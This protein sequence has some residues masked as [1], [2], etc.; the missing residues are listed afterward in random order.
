MQKSL[1]IGIV[2]AAISVTFAVLYLWFF[3]GQGLSEETAYRLSIDKANQYAAE[4]HFDLASFSKPS[5]GHQAGNRLYI[6]TWV[7]HDVA[8]NKE[9]SVSVD[10]LLVN[11]EV[12]S[13]D[14]LTHHSSGTP[15]GAP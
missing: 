6:F 14:G 3:Y 15:N 2:A 8:S 10:A 7:P 1:K 9:F 4:H 11:V 12:E 13:N 5:L